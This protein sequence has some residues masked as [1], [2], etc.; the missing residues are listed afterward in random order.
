MIEVNEILNELLS[1]CF[2]SGREER[3]SEVIKP[4]LPL[5][6]DCYTDRFGNT[7]VKLTGNEKNVLL[8]A[9]SDEI[10]LVVTNIDDEGFLHVSPCGGVDARTLINQ[11]L[12]VHGKEDIYG[13]VSSVP[14]HLLTGSSLETPEFDKILID[15]GLKNDSIST[16]VSVGDR[17]SFKRNI[18]YLQNEKVCCASLDNKA[19][20]AAII[21]ALNLLSSY[22]NVPS[23]TLLFTVQEETGGAGAGTG[24]YNIDAD[25]CICV[26]V[27]F[28]KAHG[29]PADKCGIMGKGPMVGIS[30]VLNYDFSQKLLRT[31]ENFGIPFQKEIM[32]GSTG[33]DSD[34]ISSLKTGIKTALLSIP[35]KNMH[36]SVE[37]VSLK[38]ILYTS[39][40]I[41]KYVTG[42]NIDD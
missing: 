9:H 24:A 23:V 22:K 4:L 21:Y 40:L 16:L 30:P 15:C 19:G 39:E 6:A 33:T 13:V 12:I 1:G 11:E 8:T 28:A 2:V 10:G 3:F 41:V 25:E 5:N 20:C 27:S 17:A 14:P 34:K 42:G 29:V 31:A 7:V 35:L 38:D 32:S 36:T 18:S 26:D 37:I